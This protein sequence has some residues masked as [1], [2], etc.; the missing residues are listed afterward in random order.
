MKILAML[1]AAMFGAVTVAGAADLTGSIDVEVKEWL[2]LASP[3][4]DLA[5]QTATLGVSRTMN[6]TSG[7]YTGNVVNDS[8]VIPLIVVDNDGR[9]S[10][11]LPRVVFYLVFITKEE[12]TLL[13]RLIPMV[14]F[15]S[16]NLVSSIIKPE[17]DTNIT[18][19]MSYAVDN[20]TFNDGENSNQGE[21]LTVRIFAMGFLP[22][23][24][25]GFLDEI[26]L[27]AK[28][29]FT[30]EYIT[31]VEQELIIE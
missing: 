24:A 4:I 19:P 10:Y 28:A 13:E 3:A 6:E 7:N 14:S 5:N 8:L 16:A 25:N 29:E 27:I 31:Y 2:G 9:E 12:G 23:A 26:P 30:L 21:N 1:V 20:D 22:G 15:G 17:A 11:L 18:I